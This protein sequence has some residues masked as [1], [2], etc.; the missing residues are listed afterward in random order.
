MY[1]EYLQN[2]L[3]IQHPFSRY[4]IQNRFDFYKKSQHF[5]KNL[6]DVYIKFYKSLSN[7]CNNSRTLI[8]YHTG[9]R[10]F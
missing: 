2:L 4:K 8:K 7:K 3:N 5:N 1:Q 6:Y 10:W 9:D